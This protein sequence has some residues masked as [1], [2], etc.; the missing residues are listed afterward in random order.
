MTLLD[1]AAQE[2]HT[3]VARRLL[4]QGA[5]LDEQTAVLAVQSGRLETAR[6]LLVLSRSR[7]HDPSRALLAL[8]LTTGLWQAGDANR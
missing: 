1:H 4:E 2:G 5:P 7:R 8:V 6:L 3:E